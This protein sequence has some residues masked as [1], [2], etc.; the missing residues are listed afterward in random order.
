VAAT[1]RHV[2]LDA[3][4]ATAANEVAR[5]FAANLAA[6]VASPGALSGSPAGVETIASIWLPAT[7][8]V[9]DMERDSAAALAGLA[10]HGIRVSERHVEAV[11]ATVATDEENSQALTTV[12]GVAL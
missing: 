10:A 12:P 3:A 7:T 8:I 9:G 11:T 2:E 4:A 6:T 5:S 1:Q